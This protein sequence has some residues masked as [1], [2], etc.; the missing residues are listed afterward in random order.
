[1][2]KNFKEIIEKAKS[3][4]PLPVVLAEAHDPAAL[5]A[6]LDAEDEGIAIPILVGDAG[7]INPV[8]E[9]IGRKF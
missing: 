9:S 6:L 3:K 4:G 8:L 2:V 5:S 1:M 7:K